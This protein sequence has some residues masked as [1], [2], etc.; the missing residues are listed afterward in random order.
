MHVQKI[1]D[2]KGFRIITLSCHLPVLNIAKVMALERIGTVMMVDDSGKLVG[3]LS[4]RDIIRVISEE[5]R[6]IASLSTSELRS[7]SL[8]TCS[9]YTGLED[10]LALMSKH[11]IRHLPV[12]DG[13]DLVGLI[14]VR[15]VLDLQR[16]ILYRG[17]SNA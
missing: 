15:E 2:K 5:G 17:R 9:P 11:A 6:D 1:L 8:I 10:V 14:S 16:E 3:I 4:E 7:Q 12:V 13:N